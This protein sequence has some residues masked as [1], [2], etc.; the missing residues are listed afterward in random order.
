MARTVVKFE[1]L[2]ELDRAL[3][4]I[5]KSVVKSTLVVI[6]KD[7]GK[8][9]AAAMRQNAPVKE[10]KLRDSIE[11]STRLNRRQ[12]RLY[13]QYLRAGGSKS[14]AEVYVGPSYKLGK[15]GRHGHLQ[16]F[17]TDHHPPHPF[18]RPAWA[19]TKG[20]VFE[21]MKDGL[22]K[23]VFIAAKK[24]EAKAKRLARKAARLAAQG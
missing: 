6:A 14:F 20:I 3:S 21:N 10:G 2:R 24:E 23:A 9:L 7:S 19:S 16:E 12:A 5:S 1:G 17:G 4:E 11:V 8:P 13:R 15:G 22:G 18:A